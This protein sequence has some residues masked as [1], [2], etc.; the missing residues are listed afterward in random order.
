MKVNVFSLSSDSWPARFFMLLAITSLAYLF[1]LLQKVLQQQWFAALIISLGLLL[2]PFSLWLL[3]HASRAA[4]F[5]SLVLLNLFTIACLIWVGS[6]FGSSALLALMLVMAFA[7]VM[8]NS[9]QLYVTAGLVFLIMLLIFSAT[10]LG[11]RVANEPPVSLLRFVEYCVIMTVYGLLLGAFPNLHKLL[12]A[13][14]QQAIL[15]RENFEF[16][17]RHQLPTQSW[18][19]SWLHSEQVFGGDYMLCRESSPGVWQLLL[20]DATG[21]DLPAAMA[22][23]PVLHG[24]KKQSL[25]LSE[26]FLYLNDEVQQ[27]VPQHQFVAAILIELDAQQKRLSIINAGMP[28]VLL[29]DHMGQVERRVG[30]TMLAL[31]ILPSARVSVHTESMVLPKLGAVVCFSDGL[32]A[33]H[34]KHGSGLE[35]NDLEALLPG[36]HDSQWLARIQQS[37]TLRLGTQPLRD[38]LALLLVDLN[39]FTTNQADTLLEED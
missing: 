16:M 21:Q 19:V 9:W 25:P 20:V 4:A 6:G 36:F 13:R 10:H 14:Q 26:L 33:V 23:M 1:V 27:S 32:L 3:H 34:G 35:A 24:F 7:A 38:D 5:W 28:D 11:V 37:I 31:G 2:M 12:Q 17:F 39:K 29:M 30:S 8:G 18:L 22:L 15:A